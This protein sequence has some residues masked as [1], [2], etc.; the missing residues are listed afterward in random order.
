MNKF[1][2]AVYGTVNMSILVGINYLHNIFFGEDL[3]EFYKLVSQNNG[4]TNALLK[5]VQEGLIVYFF[6]QRP[7]QSEARDVLHNE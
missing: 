4:I 6:N 7:I 1:N 2:T 3:Q 5:F